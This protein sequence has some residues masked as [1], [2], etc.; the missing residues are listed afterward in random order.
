LESKTSYFTPEASA[1][2][3]V[4]S[5]PNTAAPIAAVVAELSFM[6]TKAFAVATAPLLAGLHLGL[7]VLN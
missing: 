7:M 4:A 3:V 2:V 5:R 6:A 1:V